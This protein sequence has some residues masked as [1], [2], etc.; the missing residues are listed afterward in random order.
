MR[1]NQ[2]KYVDCLQ[3]EM[4]KL[5]T[6]ISKKN[7]EIEQLIKE[8][9]SVRQMF[10]SEGGRLKEEIETLQI[11]LKEAEARYAEAVGQY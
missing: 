9:S 4:I 1:I 10:D 11:K 6:T 2:Q 5:E 8:K 7:I 3:S